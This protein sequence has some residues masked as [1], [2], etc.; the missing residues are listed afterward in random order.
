MCNEIDR[1][2][3]SPFTDEVE[4]AL[5][6][7]QFTTPSI[8]PFKGDSDPESHLRHFKMAIILYKADDALICKVFV[9]TLRGAAQDWFHTLPSM[10]IGKFKEFALIFFKG[11]HL[12][13]DS[14]KACGPL[15]QPVQ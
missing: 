13:Q 6:P 14:Q 9:M 5:P 15:I 12:L 4:Q 7:K 10:S 1:V 8:T 3:Y 11:V 2:D